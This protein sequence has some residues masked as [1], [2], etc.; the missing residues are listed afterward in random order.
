MG[1]VIQQVS[2]L[3]PGKCSGQALA[4]S[5]PDLV[6]VSLGPAQPLRMLPFPT[7]MPPVSVSLL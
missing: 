4:Q 1:Q 6:L 7:Q 5:L 2:S 3:C